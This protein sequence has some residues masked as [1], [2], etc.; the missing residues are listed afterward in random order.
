[1]S[2]ILVVD[3]NGAVREVLRTLLSRAGYQVSAAAGGDSAIQILESDGADLALVDI[4]MP[5]MTGYELCS[6]LKTDDRW[7]GLP[8]VLMTG[9]AIAGVPE[10]VSAVGAATLIPKPFER[11][12]LFKTLRELLEANKS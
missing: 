9:R 5:G 12:M 4:E 2:R 10:Q 3:D 1:M 11:E 8:V 7:R 6:Y